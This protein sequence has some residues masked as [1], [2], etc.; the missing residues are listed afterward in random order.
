[1]LVELLRPAGPELARRWLAAL[2]L[3]P[4][5][6][7]EGIV[8]AVER[9]MTEEYGSAPGTGSELIHMVSPPVQREGHVEQVVRTF[10]RARRGR[11]SAG[12]GKKSAG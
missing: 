3:A 12:E 11:A 7:R 9:R 1:M 6:E 4:A 2:L 10:E 8:E 5:A